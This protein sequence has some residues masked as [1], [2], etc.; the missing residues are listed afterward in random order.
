MVNLLYGISELPCK[1]DQREVESIFSNSSS[2]QLLN[3]NRLN[4]EHD[5]FKDV[6]LL[7]TPAHME[8][9]RKGIL[10]GITIE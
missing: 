1:I 4:K 3:L 8:D 10:L 5:E 2:Y 6:L 7:T 9:S